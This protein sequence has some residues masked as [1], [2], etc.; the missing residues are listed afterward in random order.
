M[1]SIILSL[2][3]V[4]SFSILS[5]AQEE[6][7]NDFRKDVRDYH[8]IHHFAVPGFLVRLVGSIAVGHEDRRDYNALK[9]LIKGISNVSVWFTD[10]DV[11]L[12]SSAIER[13]K[14][15]LVDEKYEPLIKVK[16]HGEDVEIYS[17]GNSVAIKKLIIF[18][19]ENDGNNVLLYIRGRFSDRDLQNVTD[20][21][22]NE[23]NRD[24][25]KL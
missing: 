22:L 18:M 9:P 4:T 21:Y 19:K 3:F 12:P 13:L 8:G 1:K 16:D 10:D 20:Q 11:T 14:D 23:K 17:W 2:L 15:N 6:S 5:T 7:M 25:R 24:I